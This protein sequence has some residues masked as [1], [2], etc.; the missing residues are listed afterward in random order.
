M[1]FYA[2]DISFFF[3]VFLDQRDQRVLISFESIIGFA[4]C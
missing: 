3:F 2:C 4:D 1:N